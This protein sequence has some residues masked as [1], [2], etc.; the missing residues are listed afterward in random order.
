MLA[1]HASVTPWIS[2][3]LVQGNAAIHLKTAIS[4]M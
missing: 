1:R 3:D 2:K 4:A